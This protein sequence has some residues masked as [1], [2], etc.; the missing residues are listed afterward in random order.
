MQRGAGDC[1]VVYPSVT[2]TVTVTV[3]EA[4][5]LRPLLDSP[6]AH[7]IALLVDRMKQKCFQITTKRARLSQQFQLRRQP[8]PVPCSRCSNRKGSV[9]N[10]ST[11]PRRDE[12]ATRW[13]VQCRSTWN[14]GNRCQKVRYIPAYVPEATCEPASTACTASSQRLTTSAALEELESHGHASFVKMSTIATSLIIAE[15]VHFILNSMIV[16]ACK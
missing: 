4:L 3:T 7:H 14:I 6:R 2:V 8:V 1:K 16:Y 5:V 11:C 10:S 12:V 9:A 15:K 13:S